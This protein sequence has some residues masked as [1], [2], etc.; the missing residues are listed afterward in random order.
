MQSELTEL[1][2]SPIMDSV[3]A[4]SSSA[5]EQPIRE[6]HAQ[7]LIFTYFLLIYRHPWNMFIYTM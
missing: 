6:T 5:A 1:H 2:N 7:L 4:T 3:I